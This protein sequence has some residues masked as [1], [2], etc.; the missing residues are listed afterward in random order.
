MASEQDSVVMT[1]AGKPVKIDEFLFM[2]KKNGAVNLSDAKERASF[3]ELYKNF[4]LKV[5][6]AEAEG[7]TLS[8]NPFIQFTDINRF[9]HNSMYLLMF[10]SFIRPEKS[11]SFLLASK[12]TVLN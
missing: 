9:S 1:V 5:A 2:A 4:K 11:G 3:V 8:F 7:V 6:E 10:N 12:I